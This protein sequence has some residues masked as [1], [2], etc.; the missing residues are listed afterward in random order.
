MRRQQTCRGQKWR[1]LRAQVLAE[2][3]NCWLCGD[4]IDLSLPP[5]H[6]MAGQGDHVVPLEDGGAAL[7]RDNVRAAHRTCN[8][9]R[10][11]RWRRERRARIRTAAMAA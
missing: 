5:Q 2:E 3:P 6:P 10:H 11:F 7:D 4:P 8:I 9:H 1:R